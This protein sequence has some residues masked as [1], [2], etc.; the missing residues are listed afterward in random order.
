[1]PKVNWSPA[2]G[3]PPVLSIVFVTEIRP[4]LYLFVVVTLTVVPLP[5]VMLGGVVG[6]RRWA[7]R[8]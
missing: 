6:A 2:F 5:T 4:D 3:V 8:K 1:M 7:R